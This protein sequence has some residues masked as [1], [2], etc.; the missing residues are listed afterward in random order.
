MLFVS[1]T[2][3]THFIMMHR[4]SFVIVLLILSACAGRVKQPSKPAWVS[5]RPT[6]DAYYVGIGIA[7][8]TAN[9]QQ[10]QTAAKKEALNDLISEIKV[11]VSSNSVLNAMQNNDGFKQQ[12]ES[13]I[14][15]SAINEIEAYEVAGSWEDAQY[16]WIYMRLSKSGYAEMRRKRMQNAINRAEDFLARADGLDIKNNYAQVLRLKMKA[17]ITLQDYLHED[18]KTERNGVEVFLINEI[19]SSIQKQLYQ[20][21]VKTKVTT[22]SGKVG[23]P[24][25]SPFDVMVQFK[26]TDTGVL[27]VPYV[28]MRMQVEQG[29]MEF[30]AQ[31]ETDHLGVSS[32]TIARILGRDPIQLLRLSIDVFGLV[33]NDSINFAIRNVLYNIDEPSTVLRV[34]VIPIKIF[35]QTDEK[36]LS[37]NM[38]NKVLELLLKRELVERGCNFVNNKSEADYVITVQSNTKALGNIWGNMQSASLDLNL[39]LFDNKNNVEI[40]RDGLHDIRGFQTTPENAG[41]DA[42][43]SAQQQLLKKIIPALSE[44]LMYQEK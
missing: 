35:M 24:I 13:Q 32:F 7:P 42:Y 30:G 25:Q 34:Q 37:A 5:Q 4:K 21:Q 17:L 38:N 3:A 6:S 29:K 9:P 23:K 40:F 2:S 28:P 27:M 31:T 8:K 10:Y 43:K 12:F 26:D 22:L 44:Q 36:N 41:I 1:K 16:Y 20:V 11:S 14:K 19:I 39:S 33:K 15:L 18:I